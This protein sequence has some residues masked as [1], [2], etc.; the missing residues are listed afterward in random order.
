MSIGA[1][2]SILKSFAETSSTLATLRSFVASAYGQLTNPEGSKTDHYRTFFAFVEG[3]EGLLNDFGLWCSGREERICRAQGGE[4]P[5]ETVTLLSLKRD[6]EAQTSST[7][8]VLRTIVQTILPS[9]TAALFDFTK[10]NPSW[11]S[12]TILD[13]LL[14]HSQSHLCMGDA[15][16][17][18]T[19]TRVFVHA[20]APLWNTVRLWIKVG[21]PV[22][23]PESTT[24]HPIPD[25]ITD[26]EFFIQVIGG[27]SDTSESW[28]VAAVLRT[29]P[30]KNHSGVSR[31]EVLVPKFLES[32][33]ASL[34]SAGKAIGLLRALGVDDFF[35]PQDGKEWV[36]E[37]VTCE[38]LF[39]SKP[40]D[41]DT[42]PTVP[43]TPVQGLTV[44]TSARLEL[45]AIDKRLSEASTEAL[46]F[47]ASEY[48]AP[49]CQAAQ[50][51]LNL[52]LGEDC[53]LWD[54][55]ECM[56]DVYLMGRGDIMTHFCDV[57][58]SR[59]RFG[60]MV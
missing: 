20:V 5:P 46:A 7:F 25:L 19:L 59:V 14:Q 34:L 56:Q 8:A 1:F 22:E 45:Q 48:L 28:G 55:L 18:S 40:R 49:F 6:I 33:G 26:R 51:R 15:A 37:W 39:S 31:D 36:D 13:E 24:Y 58:F 10:V 17:A 44:P 12:K 60:R 32:A 4:G 52:L 43:A 41:D 2:H 30:L 35:H 21:V 9:S 53:R 29:Q 50:A 11:L 38:T 27:I 16:T 42:S 47:S 54:R 23:E 57:L 3:I